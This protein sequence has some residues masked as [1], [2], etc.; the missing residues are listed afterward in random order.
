MSCN[1]KLTRL[2]LYQLY[3]HI[4]IDFKNTRIKRNVFLATVYKYM[5]YIYTCIILNTGSLIENSINV[6][7][8][9]HIGP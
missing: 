1:S 2:K 3:L 9:F 4:R 5:E 6:S 8:P 7:K